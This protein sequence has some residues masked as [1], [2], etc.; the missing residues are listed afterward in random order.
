[1]VES[2]PQEVGLLRTIVRYLERTPIPVDPRALAFWLAQGIE[3][4]PGEPT[5]KT[6]IHPA[7]HDAFNKLS[8][9]LMARVKAM[10]REANFANLSG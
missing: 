2:L 9:G 4:P 3:V 1:M 10:E 7:G 8:E 6:T 5:W